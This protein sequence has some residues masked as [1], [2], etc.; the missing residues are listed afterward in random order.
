MGA[1]DFNDDN[2]RSAMFSFA[3]HPSDMN[4]PLSMHCGGHN[5]DLASTCIIQIPDYT[6]RPK[7]VAADTVASA[8]FFHE[9]QQAVFNCLL[10]VRAANDDGGA[11][12]KV[13]AYIG[14]TAW[15]FRPTWHAHLLVWVYS[16]KSREQ[17][18]DDLGTK[19][20]KLSSS[21]GIIVMSR[22]FFPNNRCLPSY[23]RVL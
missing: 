13:K 2:T 19:L 7:T 20:N 4:G 12:G 22:R 21:R 16:Y 1:G 15:Q 6:S 9:T 14:K 11:L 8:T 5:I 18:R 10:R 3:I 23:V 17:L